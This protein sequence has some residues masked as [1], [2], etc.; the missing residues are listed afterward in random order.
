[1]EYFGLVFTKH[2]LSKMQERGIKKENAWE[3]FK[4]PDRYF[5]GKKK[6]T[7]E[8]QKG[9]GEFRLTVVAAQNPRGEWITISVWRDPPLAGT[10][11]AKENAEWRK[12]RQAGFLGKILLGIK[13]RLG[14]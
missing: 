5:E 12:Y 6:D 9:F 8:F 13:R 14:I 1:M 2:A 7:F 11:D 10:A 4:H 3:T